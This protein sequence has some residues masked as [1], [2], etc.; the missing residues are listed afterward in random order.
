MQKHGKAGDAGSARGPSLMDRA[1]A[2]LRREIITCQLPPGSEISELEIADRLGMSKTPVREAL[3]R[4]DIEGFVE[5]FPRRGYRIKPITL[6]DINDLFAVRSVLEQSA[7]TLAARSMSD[8][9]LDHLSALAAASYRLE[10]HH[11]LDH[12]VETNRLF[13]E[14]IAEGSGNPR[15]AAL[16]M[17]HI[18]ESERFFYIGARSR[19]VN[20]ETNRD[21]AGIVQVLRKR[22]GPA[23]GHIMGQHIDNTHKGLAT[24]LLTSAT[25]GVSL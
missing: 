2:I 18:E 8:L 5:T 25:G 6:R 19:D 4:L 23:A 7:A 14:A 11:S 16:V 21:H 15:L 10:E 12:F 20:V 1:Y 17:A 9:Q 3:G 13:H 24:S 22:D